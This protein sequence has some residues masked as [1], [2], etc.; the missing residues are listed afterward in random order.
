[1]YNLKCNKS[2]SR[3]SGVRIYRILKNFHLSESP[4]YYSLYFNNTTTPMK[5]GKGR[6][7][8]HGEFF[9]PWTI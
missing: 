1:M 7:S 6:T 4:K 5:K 3:N 9:A 8:H 2:V